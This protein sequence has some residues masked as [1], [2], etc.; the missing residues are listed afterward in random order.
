[1]R[2]FTLPS[3][4]LIEAYATANGDMGPGETWKYVFSKCDAARRTQLAS[5]FGV[6][7]IYSTYVQPQ[8]VPNRLVQYME[9]QFHMYS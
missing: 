2:L 5:T 3:P 9:Y 6:Y 1:M 7:N 8:Q 4:N